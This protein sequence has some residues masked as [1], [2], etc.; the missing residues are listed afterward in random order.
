MNW[1][2]KYLNFINTIKYSHNYEYLLVFFIK[3]YIIFK[4][5]NCNLTLYT[6]RKINQLSSTY[7]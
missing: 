5:I 1:S 3:F 4:F 7:G 6:K 2:F